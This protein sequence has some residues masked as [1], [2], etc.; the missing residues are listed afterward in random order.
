MAEP[1]TQYRLIILYMLDQVEH[2][3]TNTQI[4]N[5]VLKQNYTNYFTLQ[6]CLND[7]L[8]SELIVSENT[9]NDVC[10]RITPAGRET[11][12]YLQDKITDGV[13][14][15]VRD[16]LL[17]HEKV[18]REGVLVLADFYRTTT[19]DYVAHCQIKDRETPMLEISIRANT[20]PQ[21]EAICKN[22]KAQ[23]G[24]VY[25]TILEKLIR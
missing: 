15:D 11:F 20:K 14:A 16:Y 8:S 24:E 7:L 9:Y 21:A 4:S 5:F 25:E 10:Y 19:S 17:K 23:S 18:L 6:Q 12:S 13:K 3:L 2:P 22:W 1:N